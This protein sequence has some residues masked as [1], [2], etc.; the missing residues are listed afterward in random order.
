[1]QAA[2]VA[3]N[4]V[5]FKPQLLHHLKVVVNDKRLGKLGIK[6][7][8]DCLC[9]ANLTHK[10]VS[11][12]RTFLYTVSVKVSLINLTCVCRRTTYEPPHLTPVGP[13]AV[14]EKDAQRV[15]L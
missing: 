3:V 9:P 15:R 6:A 14:H 4:V 8:L 10:H 13:R 7:V 5:H 11:E 2:V 1:M 12:S